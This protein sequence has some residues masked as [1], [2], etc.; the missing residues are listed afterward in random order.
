MAGCPQPSEGVAGPAR[1]R[2][3]RGRATRGLLAGERAIARSK[4]RQRNEPLLLLLGDYPKALELY[5][6]A[7]Q[8]KLKALGPDHAYVATT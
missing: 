6:Q 8:I 5:E 3:H 4:F 7:L 1:R 2:H